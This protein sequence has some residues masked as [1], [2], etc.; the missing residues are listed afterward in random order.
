MTIS[1]D[2]ICF[3]D[4]TS[5]MHMYICTHPFS[6]EELTLHHIVFKS[7]IT[8]S[9]DQLHTF[10]IV[11]DHFLMCNKE[12]LHLHIAGIGGSGKLHIINA[13]DNLFTRCNACDQLQVTA[14]IGCAAVLIKGHTI[15]ALML[16]LNGWCT[17]CQSE[18][19]II[20]KDVE[21][22]II[23]K[24]LL[25]SAHLLCDISHHLCMAKLADLIAAST[26]FGGVNVIFT[27]DFE[28]LKPV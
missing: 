15:H 17:I 3:C 26:P 28:Q 13:L 16:L 25:V 11:V 8:N 20:W 23:D 14:L 2:P 24:I 1:C 9:S 18:L 7:G 21:Y 5:W 27:G 10:M 6:A 12:Q 19:E 22:L 4:S